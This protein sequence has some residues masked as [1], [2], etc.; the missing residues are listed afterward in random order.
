[1]LEAIVPKNKWFQRQ[2]PCQNDSFQTATD[3]HRLLKRSTVRFLQ[4]HDYAQGFFEQPLQKYPHRKFVH[5][6]K[7]KALP[8]NFFP[9]HSRYLNMT[10]LTA[11]EDNHAQS[12]PPFRARYSSHSRRVDHL[13]RVDRRNLKKKTEVLP[14]HP[15]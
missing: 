13:N 6:G 10:N 2:S 14:R 8:A 5:R 1:M 15:P 12:S 7:A 9:L 4:L 11:T 3:A